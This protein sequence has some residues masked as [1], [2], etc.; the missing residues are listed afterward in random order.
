M[1]CVC[2]CVLVSGMGRK[3]EHELRKGK[4]ENDGSIMI[5]RNEYPQR[6]QDKRS[7]SLSLPS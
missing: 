3:S 5:Q 4:T 6:A 1:L 2:V 7:Q